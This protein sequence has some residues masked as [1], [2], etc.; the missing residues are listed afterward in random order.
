MV[1]F[2]VF[3]G[4]VSDSRFLTLTRYLPPLPSCTLTQAFWFSNQSDVC[5]HLRR[6]PNLRH[7]V[8]RCALQTFLVR[9][10]LP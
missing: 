3:L 1:Q 2:V 7:L 9:K 8:R 6:Q 10:D 4:Q 5:Q